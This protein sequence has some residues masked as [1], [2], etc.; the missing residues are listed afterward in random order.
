MDPSEIDAEGLLPTIQKKLGRIGVDI[1]VPYVNNSYSGCKFT[2]ESPSSNNEI[3]CNY[4]FAWIFGIITSYNGRSTQNNFKLYS[5][6]GSINI[7]GLDGSSQITNK[8]FFPLINGGINKM[9]ISS[10]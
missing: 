8:L 1:F 7:I 4:A 10:N 5:R 3:D 6:S 2:F 9:T